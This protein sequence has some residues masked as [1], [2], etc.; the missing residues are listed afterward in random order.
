V[1]RRASFVPELGDHA[2]RPGLRF[3]ITTLCLLLANG[4]GRQD[5]REPDANVDRSG[6]METLPNAIDITRV[7]PDAWEPYV[8]PVTE[9]RGSRVRPGAGEQLL[10]V[11]YKDVDDEVKTVTYAMQPTGYFVHYEAGVTVRPQPHAK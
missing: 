1:A 11:R 4:C 3:P 6:Q 10:R 2:V 8:E 9:L 5:A 7:T